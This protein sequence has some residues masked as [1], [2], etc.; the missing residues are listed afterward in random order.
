MAVVD[1]NTIDVAS[2]SPVS[3]SLVQ[4]NL[5]NGT[6]TVLGQLPSAGAAL[7]ARSHDGLDHP[8]R[9][10]DRAWQHGIASNRGIR[11]D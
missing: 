8:P 11:P 10:R 2:D 5:V 7:I 6:N 4:V 9:R 1:P 3:Q